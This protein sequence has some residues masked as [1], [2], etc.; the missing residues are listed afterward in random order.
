VTKRIPLG[1][2]RVAKARNLAFEKGTFVRQEDEREET[3]M[4]VLCEFRVLHASANRSGFM[5][6][7]KVWPFFIF[8]SFLFFSF[9]F[10]FL[11]RTVRRIEP[12]VVGQ[13]YFVSTN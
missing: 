1:C 4:K 9:L 6:R 13:D 11:K 3:E 2:Q 10:H 12:F 5:D 8:F 7:E